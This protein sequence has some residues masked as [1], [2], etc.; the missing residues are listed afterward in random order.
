MINNVFPPRSHSQ[1]LTQSL[2]LR[3]DKMPVFGMRGDEP[4]RARGASSS[5][6]DLIKTP[7]FLSE[8]MAMV[9]ETLNSVKG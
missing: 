9:F 2:P 3:A 5:Q 4:L 7:K 6:G 8:T 1:P